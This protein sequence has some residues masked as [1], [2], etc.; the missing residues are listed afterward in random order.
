MTPIISRADAKATSSKH[1]FTGKPCKYGHVS[2]RLV[3]SKGCVE[4]NR[5]QSRQWYAA[6]PAKLREYA[7]Q[8]RAANPEY[9]RQRYANDPVFKFMRNLRPAC[10]KFSKASLNRQDTIALLGCDLKWFLTEWA[11]VMLREYS[12]KSGVEMTPENYGKVWDWDHCEALAGFN[13]S[14][15]TWQ[16]IAWRWDNLRPLPAAVNRSKG[17][18]PPSPEEMWIGIPETSL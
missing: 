5:E 7:R 10:G 15:P 3:S 14:D 6:N 2:E 4:C 16:R 18:S 9:E 1:Y 11:P 13:Q 8:R 12:A 17:T